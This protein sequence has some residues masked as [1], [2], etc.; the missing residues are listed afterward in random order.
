R[1]L[2][3]RGS[4]DLLLSRLIREMNI[5]IME[6]ISKLGSGSDLSMSSGG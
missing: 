6:V 3:T 2:S 5:D 1:N 4:Y